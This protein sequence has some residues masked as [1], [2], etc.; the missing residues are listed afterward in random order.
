MFKWYA[1]AAIC[2]AYL[3]D[4]SILRHHDSAHPPF[5]Q[6]RW[7]TRGWTLQELI[8]PSALMFF[9]KDWKEIG[10]RNS[11]ATTISQRTGIDL[12]LFSDKHLSIPG[13]RRMQL[14]DYTIAQ[15]MSWASARQTE[16]IEDEAY[17]LFGLF[18]INMPLLYGEGRMAFVRLQEEILRRSS[19]LSLFAWNRMVRMGEELP[20]DKL[21]GFLADSPD[22]FRNSGDVIV[23]PQKIQFNVEPYGI[24]NR[25]IQIKLP[26]VADV[27]PNSTSTEWGLQ[28]DTSWLFNEFERS[29]QHAAVLNC[30]YSG[31]PQSLITIPVKLQENATEDS[32]PSY[33]RM[34]RLGISH[35]SAEVQAM[36]RTVYLQATHDSIG[37]HNG[38]LSNPRDKPLLL[39]RPKLSR[40]RMS[41]RYLTMWPPSSAWVTHESGLLSTKLSNRGVTYISYDNGICLVVT[42]NGMNMY[43]QVINNA[44]VRQAGWDLVAWIQ[45]R[46]TESSSI[47]EDTNEDGLKYI[48]QTTKHLFGF[49]IELDVDS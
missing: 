47:Q 1:D 46:R 13:Q 34:G 45:K 15:R 44:P 11:L 16:R 19:D 4:V 12:A 40:S 37:S 30:V 20:H 8:A 3:E 28:V 6:S 9:D 33:Y 39:I 49:L 32:Y 17:C 43:S 35:D 2:Y 21:T 36:R 29:Q 5:E 10:S 7:F 22:C 38:L 48:A 31:S 41:F 26:I 42:F 14:S 24:T 25:G 18:D 23:P 27:A